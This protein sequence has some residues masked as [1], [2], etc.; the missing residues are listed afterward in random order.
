M[1]GAKT[2]LLVDDEAVISLSQAGFLREN[3]FD[4]I[5]AFNGPEAI[6]KAFSGGV[7]DMVLMDVDLGDGMDGIEAAG[8]IL[9]KMDI[10]LLFLSSHTEPA[11]VEKTGSVASCG[12]VV[13]QSG[14]SVLMASINMAFR[15]HETGRRIRQQ[16][17]IE[18]L[19]DTIPAPVFYKDTNLRYTGC[20]RAFEEFIGI[21]RDA[22]TGKTVYQVAPPE[23]A[24]KYEE[25]DI[26]LLANP[27]KQSYECK[28]KGRGNDLRDVIFSKATFTGPDNSVEGIVGII[29]DVTDMNRARDELKELSEKRKELEFI[30][31]R[32]PVTVWLW[33]AEPG[34]PVKYVSAGIRS[35]GYEPEDFISGRM[36]YADIIHPEDI[37]RVQAETDRFLAEKRMEYSQEYRLRSR[38]G[39]I[40][41]V[42]DRTYIRVR[43][44]GTVESSQGIVMDITERKNAE[45]AMTAAVEQNR[46]LYMELQHRVKNTMNIITGIINIESDSLKDNPAGRSLESIRDRVY[47]LSELYSVLYASGSTTEVRLDRYFENIAK[48][49]ERSLFRGKG[50]QII[51]RCTNV[52][53]EVR[54]ATSMGLIL[55]ELITNASK[56][57]RGEGGENWIEV[58]LKLDEGYIVLEVEDNGRGLPPDFDIRKSTGLGLQLVYGLTIQHKGTVDVSS[59][60]TTVFRIAVPSN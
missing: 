57:A 29:N 38:M 33:S 14:G 6:K 31:D 32:S 4:V 22:I 15:L 53:A 37:V 55:N 10:P 1:I 46:M 24:M 8:I 19:I 12:Y 7:I 30:I 21:S 43:T 39:E 17:F 27:G 51:T 56:Y 48:S 40:R 26:E 3:G 13:K 28:V 50:F 5:T 49:L 41:W 52:T 60:G 59:S 58:R 16:K 34:W 45:I 47:T 44:D 54:T 35:L 23:L 20:N 25:T 11:F 42:D 9:E 2:I 18:T 36:T